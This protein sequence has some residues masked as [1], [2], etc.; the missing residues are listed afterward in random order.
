MRENSE[1]N[2]KECIRWKGLFEVTSTLQI[3]H[4]YIIK[5]KSLYRHLPRFIMTNK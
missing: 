5:Y 1:P 2:T 3:Y 4:F